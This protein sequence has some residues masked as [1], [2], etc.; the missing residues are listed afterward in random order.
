MRFAWNWRWVDQKDDALGKNDG[1]EIGNIW[2]IGDKLGMGNDL[3][4]DNSLAIGE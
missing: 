1:F 2:E 4:I 3:E